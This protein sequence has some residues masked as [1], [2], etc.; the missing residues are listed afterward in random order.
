MLRRTLL[1]CLLLVVG[2]GSTKVA[3]S[4]THPRQQAQTENLKSGI[5]QQLSKGQSLPAPQIVSSAAPQKSASV[6]FSDD[7][8][9][10]N[11]NWS[12]QGNLWQIGQ[13]TSGPGFANSGTRCA[14]TNLGG[15][16]PDNAAAG[17]LSRNITLPTLPHPRSALRLR[18]WTWYETENSYD[19]GR[20]WISTDNGQNWSSLRIYEGSLNFWAPSVID[21]SAYAG[22]TIRLDFYFTSDGSV[23]YAGWYIDDVTIELTE[24]ASSNHVEIAVSSNGQF[25]MGM[26]GGPVLLFGHPSPWSSATT[27]QIDGQ[28]FWNYR[29]QPWGTTVSPPT[30][31][32]LTNTGVW[33]FPNNVQVR[34]TL[35]IVQGSSTGNFDTGEIRYTVTNND[36]TAHQI[37]LRVMLDTMLGLNDGAPFRVPSAGAVTTEQEWDANRMPPYFQAFDDLNN[38]TVQSQGTLVGGNALR[39]DRF[40]TTGW[41]HINDTPWEYITIPGRDYYTPGYGYD[42]AIGIFWLPTLLQS[43]ETK[44]FVTYY[45]LGGIDVDIQPP[46]VVGLS[47]PHSLVLLNGASPDNPFTLAVYLSNSSPGVTQTARGIQ[48]MLTLP[49]GLVLAS[50]ENAAHQ[51]ADM[52]VNADQ[53]TD[54]RIQVQPA[55]AGE[56]TYSLFV[57]AANITS[58]TLAKSVF[59]FGIETSPQNAET[60]AANLQEISAVFNVA[61]DMAS[62]NANTFKLL[63]NSG[64]AVGGTISYEVASR[65]AKFQLQNYLQPDRAYT[66][67]LSSEIKSREGKR[68]P[69]T[70]VWRFRTARDASFYFV[71]KQGLIDYFTHKQFYSEEESRAQGYLDAVKGRFD[72]HLATEAEIESIARIGLSENMAKEGLTDADAIAEI[73]TRGASGT[74]NLMFLVVGHTSGLVQKVEK[75]PV[76]GKILVRPLRRVQRGLLNLANFTA[77]TFITKVLAWQPRYFNWGWRYGQK[78][79]SVAAKKKLDEAVDAGF[80]QGAGWAL[81]QAGFRLMAEWT[82]QKFFLGSLYEEFSNESV[83]KG[84]DL[85]MAQPP[86]FVLGQQAAARNQVETKAAEM[87]ATTQEAI[88]Y[89]NTVLDV[90]E[91]AEDLSLWLAVAALLIAFVAAVGAGIAAAST[92]AGIGAAAALLAGAVVALIKIVGILEVAVTTAKLT[93]TAIMTGYM[94]LLL[95]GYVDQGTNL[96]FDQPPEVQ[97]TSVTISNDIA[98]HSATKAQAIMNAYSARSTFIKDSGENYK[99]ALQNLRDLIPRNEAMETSFALDEID[100]I[101]TAYSENADLEISQILWA[102]LHAPNAITAFDSLYLQ[103]VEVSKIYFNLREIAFHL[104]MGAHQLVPDSRALQNLAQSQI[105]TLLTAIDAQTSRIAMATSALANANIATSPLVEIRRVES[106]AT[107]ER[108]VAFT[109]QAI[110]E[111]LAQIPVNAVG[112]KLDFNDKPGIRLDNALQLLPRLEANSSASFVWEIS[113]EGQ[114]S[115]LVGSIEIIPDSLKSNFGILSPWHV[116]LFVSPE[117]TPSTGGR[118]EKG[119]VYIYPNPFN[120]QTETAVMRYSLLRDA[121]INIKVYDVSNHLVRILLQNRQRHAGTEYAEPWDGRNDKGEIVA[122]GVYFYVIESSSGERAVGKVAV[123][124]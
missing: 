17:L 108:K 22:S 43:G 82:K 32:G 118:L 106:P 92:G 52:P 115:V 63:D 102:F 46:L 53:Q 6:I 105:D 35:T 88:R 68:L 10:N 57:G 62:I 107:I 8:E 29:Y 33:S 60:V 122:N 59:V 96:A 26:P 85:A 14:A 77:K 16:Y 21:L 48:T 99:R 25:T 100:R 104:A 81:D 124:R 12:F 20:V 65:T 86:S 4:Q 101:G 7:F 56:Q 70:M 1:L 73:A 5:S 83:T 51:L 47:A 36:A 45:G 91:E 19:Q 76:I 40:V 13:P 64:S 30:T 120:P 113:Y 15:N 34:Q 94:G 54:Y 27:I 116:V 78:A 37:G 58:K 41:E 75:I 97:L 9:T 72:N 69:Q 67:S 123:L 84:V 103:P 114:D 109:V 121:E 55:A 93:D 80:E 28:D 117:T 49:S 3:L 44:E 111:N 38:P 95:A 119:N 39:P 79:F 89:G 11:S 110:C 71:E 24:I 23:N 31:N 61:M 42:S 50:G 18:F 98:L 112:V 2:F 90:A 87:H 66:V 74:I